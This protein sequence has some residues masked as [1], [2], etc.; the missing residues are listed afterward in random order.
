MVDDQLTIS[1]ERTRFELQESN[2]ALALSIIQQILA[3]GPVI[4]QRKVFHQNF[5]SFLPGIGKQ[6]IVKRQPSPSQNFQ[7]NCQ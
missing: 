2:A 5:L 1:R 7:D 4:V 3:R 6:A